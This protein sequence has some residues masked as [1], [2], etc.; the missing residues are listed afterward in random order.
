MI[1]VLSIPTTETGPLLFYQRAAMDE[2]KG[3][4]QEGASSD[5]CSGPC[6]VLQHRLLCQIS[7]LNVQDQETILLSMLEKIRSKDC[8]GSGSVNDVNFAEP[9]EFDSW[10]RKASGKQPETSSCPPA[11]PAGF[12]SWGRKASGKQ[13]EASSS[14]RTFTRKDFLEAM[15][16]EEKEREILASFYKRG[17]TSATRRT[18]HVLRGTKRTLDPNRCFIAVASRSSA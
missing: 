14:A 2:E 7:H 6:P 16:D 9:A 11:E 4:S 5:G 12:D 8:C 3:Q 13:P 18:V 1:A 15:E 17:D 10:G